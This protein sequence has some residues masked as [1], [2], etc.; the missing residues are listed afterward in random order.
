MQNRT[1]LPALLCLLAIVV[2]GLAGWT[3]M[4]VSYTELRKNALN[5]LFRYRTAIQY[6]LERYQPLPEI[7]AG[8]P[9]LVDG[10]AQRGQLQDINL[11]L[12]QMAQASEAS[13]IYLMDAD[14]NTIAASNWQSPVNFLGKNFSYRPYFQRAMT[15][16]TGYYFALGTTSKT[17][18]YYFARRIDIDGKAAGVLVVKL[19]MN[20]IEEA[21]ESPWDR[22][23][24]AFVVTDNSSVVFISTQPKWLF[25]TLQPLSEEQQTQLST[26]RRYDNLPLS[27]LTF[28]QE[29]QPYSLEGTNSEIRRVGL[30]R[31]IPEQ[32][33]IQR[34]AMP[35]ADW[36]LHLFI[37]TTSVYSSMLT[38]AMIAA[39]S[40]VVLL[41]GWLYLRERR[42]RY[43][44]MKKAR[45]TLNRTVQ[46]RTRELKSAN[47]Q[48]VQAAKLAVLGQM[49]A[50]INHELNQP[51]TAIRS[52]AENAMT[53]LERDRPATALQNMSE[54]TALTDHM[55]SIVRQLKV[56]ARKSDESSVP[57]DINMAL[58]AALRIVGPTIKNSQAQVHRESISQT[59]LVVYADLVRLEQVIV[60]LLSNALEAAKDR[61]IP[62]VW[63]R[64]R[65]NHSMAELQIIDNGCGLPEGDSEQI[66]E[67]F[68]TTR[69][70]DQGLGL[71]LSITRHIVQSL[72]GNIS[73]CNTHDGGACFTVNLP[74]VTE[75][76]T[77]INS[78]DTVQKE[79]E[80]QECYD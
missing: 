23:E 67:P 68:F 19:D 11:Y 3:G 12:S 5:E 75:S 25:H 26:E 78:T 58:T 57:V 62:T 42:R 16:G 2:V 24:A 8:N 38:A 39:T 10:L 46:E 51:L 49:S 50:G 34:V 40:M 61:E 32:F 60:N 66:F 7:I 59:P 21:W 71:G 77:V 55:S 54:I 76:E 14:G 6:L 52:Y 27:P 48:L 29:E 64:L 63:I 36:Q 45:D 20:G 28:L 15:E 13:V 31:Q 4:Q 30:K 1:R 69:S 17:R 22:H 41:F 74:L 56:F 43:Q 37:R 18:G 53:F 79:K 9:R 33:L 80:R 72:E 47:H 70:I 65:Q 44:A 73:A 35:E